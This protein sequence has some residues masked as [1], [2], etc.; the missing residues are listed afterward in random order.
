MTLPVKASRPQVPSSTYGDMN[1]SRKSAA[2]VVGL[3]D[4]TQ[5]H[6]RNLI[7]VRTPA[8]GRHKRDSPDLG[9]CGRL[10][11]DM[12]DHS[13]AKLRYRA[14][15]C[16]VQPASCDRVQTGEGAAWPHV[17]QQLTTHIAAMVAAVQV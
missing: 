12:F 11:Q 6:T 14:Y 8:P 17:V 5:V 13:E 9:A 15:R 4:S 2:D 16:D 1:H 10:V 7:S 3:R